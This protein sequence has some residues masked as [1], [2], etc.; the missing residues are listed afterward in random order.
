V[1]S[2]ISGAA[3]ADVNAA[4][5]DPE[6]HPA[7]KTDATKTDTAKAD[8]AKA[9]TVEIVTPKATAPRSCGYAS[10][11]SHQNPSRDGDR[12][13]QWHGLRNN[14]PLRWLMP[15]RFLLTGSD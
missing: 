8:T 11:S 5:P 6:L 3:A 9:D 7:T 10:S 13:P 4:L 12:A 2:G 14:R 1:I 15:G